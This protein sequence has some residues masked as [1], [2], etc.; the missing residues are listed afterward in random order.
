MHP[1]TRIF[2]SLPWPCHRDRLE[3]VE[4]I[5]QLLLAFPVEECLKSVIGF[6]TAL[7]NNP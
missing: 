3:P 1:A 4:L 2:S 7:T 6:A 5:F